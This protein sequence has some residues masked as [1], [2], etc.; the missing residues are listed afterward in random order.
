MENFE[1][2]Y[3]REEREGGKWLV[4][5]VIYKE[6]GNFDKLVDR[7][8]S[9]VPVDRNRFDS[10]RVT[11]RGFYWKEVATSKNGT[12]VRITLEYKGKEF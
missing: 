3:T 11:D 9:W 6:A 5:E 10:V 1:A 8:K 4:A 7:A 2:V 12:G